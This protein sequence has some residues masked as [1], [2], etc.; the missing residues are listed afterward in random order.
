[1]ARLGEPRFLGLYSLV[2]V[3]L[4]LGLTVVLRVFHATLFGP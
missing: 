2:A 1:V 3:A 4:G